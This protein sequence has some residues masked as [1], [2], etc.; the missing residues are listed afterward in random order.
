MR[1]LLIL[2]I[3]FVFSCKKE[4]KKSNYSCTSRIISTYDTYTCHNSDHINV[5]TYYNAYQKDIDAAIVEHNFD[6][7][8]LRNSL[9]ACDTLP[10]NGTDSM[11]SQYSQTC[12]TF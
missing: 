4:D 2:V 8:E 1:Y 12:H 5:D 7:R 6:R 11:R 3:L 10:A 9:P